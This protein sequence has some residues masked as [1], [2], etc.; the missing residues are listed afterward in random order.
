MRFAALLDTA[1][2][3]E[4]TPEV[5]HPYRAR[6]GKALWRIRLNDF[7]EMALYTLLVDD[8]EVGDVEE[9]PP[10]WKRPA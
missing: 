2:T 10:A 9:W 6:V 1:V 3:W 8:E 7:P 4:K 5:D